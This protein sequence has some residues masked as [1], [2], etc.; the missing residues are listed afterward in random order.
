MLYGNR[1]NLL[2]R[3]YW[4]DAYHS[5]FT[6]VKHPGMVSSVPLLC[7]CGSLQKAQKNR[8]DKEFNLIPI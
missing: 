2:G 3:F 6:I 5:Q 1:L 7:Y 4:R 8:R